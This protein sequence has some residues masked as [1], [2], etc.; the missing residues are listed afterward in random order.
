MPT[1]FILP[2]L[3]SNIIFISILGQCFEFPM[4]L[5]LRRFELQTIEN[6]EKFV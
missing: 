1:I 2:L 3:K 4:Q 6:Y 5:E